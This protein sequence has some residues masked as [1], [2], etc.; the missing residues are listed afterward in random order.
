[1][2]A[3]LNLRPSACEADLKLYNGNCK[4]RWKPFPH[5]E[6]N[7]GHGGESAGSSLRDHVGWKWRHIFAMLSSITEAPWRKRNY[8]RRTFLERSRSLETRIFA[9]VFLHACLIILT[10]YSTLWKVQ[11]GVPVWDLVKELLNPYVI[12]TILRD[13]MHF[14]AT[15]QEMVSAIENLAK[16]TTP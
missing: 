10:R 6:S 13:Q 9:R 8:E 4:N 2:R 1:M 16:A 14:V 12:K 15:S 11:K 3:G 7:P 5:G